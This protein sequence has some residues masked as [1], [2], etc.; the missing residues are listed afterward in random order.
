MYHNIEKS[1]LH[2]GRYVGYSRV[3]VWR[4]T[5]NG[6]RWQAINESSAKYFFANTLR[7]V[8]HELTQR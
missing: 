7:E 3:G 6:K 2:K 8:S 5:R 4:I 1:K